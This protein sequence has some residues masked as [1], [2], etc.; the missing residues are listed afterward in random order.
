M[1]PAELMKLGPALHAIGLTSEDALERVR[2]ELRLSEA[3]AELLRDHYRLIP[4][5]PGSR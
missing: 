5:V 4:G 2:Y 3:R 1:A